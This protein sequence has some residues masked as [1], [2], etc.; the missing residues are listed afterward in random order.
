MAVVGSIVPPSSSSITSSTLFLAEQWK[1]LAGL[2]GNVK[3][4]KKRLNGMFVSDS[5]IIDTCATYHVTGN[6]G[7]FHTRVNIDPCPVGLS[8]GESVVA[9]QTSIVI[10]SL[11]ITLTHIQYVPTYFQLQFTFDFSFH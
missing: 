5:W 6:K 10:L 3:I 9:T 4:P 11:A 7:L 2:L 8:N 1:A